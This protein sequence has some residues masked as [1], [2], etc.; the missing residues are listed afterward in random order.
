MILL[1]N[2]SWSKSGLH[3]CNISNCYGTSTVSL[4]RCSS[5]LLSCLGVY[6]VGT[7]PLQGPE[8]QLTCIQEATDRIE[9]QIFKSH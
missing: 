9:T 6:D 5:L 8:A 2:L 4:Y 1:L 7:K 3:L